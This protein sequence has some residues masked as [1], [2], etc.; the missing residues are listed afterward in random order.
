[1]ANGLRK[2][3]YFFIQPQHYQKAK[4]NLSISGSRSPVQRCSE[5]LR[6]TTRCHF[7]AIRSATCCPL[8]GKW[9]GVSFARKVSMY[10]V[11]RKSTRMRSRAA[12]ISCMLL[13]VL[14]FTANAVA[15]PSEWQ[16]EVVDGGSGKSVGKYTALVIDKG[17]NLHIGYFD[18]TRGALRYAFRAAGTASW[19]TMEV[20]ASGGFESLAVDSKG[21]P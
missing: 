5:F 14:L 21:H 13:G 11:H 10:V 16:V 9:L 4:S 18:E 20:D 12:W 3:H 7:C 8:W 6:G 17:D 19:S 15:G 1:M 2:T